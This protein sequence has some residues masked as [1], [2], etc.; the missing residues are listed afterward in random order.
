MKMLNR[1]FRCAKCKELATK[2]N[3]KEA[4]MN[5][6]GGAAFP[7]V[8]GG[9]TD[10]LVMKFGEIIIRDICDFLDMLSCDPWPD[11]LWPAAH[12]VI[13]DVIKELSD[14]NFMTDSI[15]SAWAELNVGERTGREPE[16]EELHDELDRLYRR[17][18]ERKEGE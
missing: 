17:A 7:C 11:N 16:A 2:R 6:D 14:G 1:T 3:E 9:C 4:S 12:D 8:D 15:L 13:Q 18:G 5:K 10:R